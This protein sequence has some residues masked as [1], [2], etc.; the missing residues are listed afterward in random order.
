[1]RSKDQILLENLYSNQILKEGNV[2]DSVHRAISRRIASN[3]V[4]LLR[5]YG[6]EKVLDAVNQVASH[7][8]EG[9]SLEDIG[10]SDV[11]AWVNWVVKDLTRGEN[12]A[13]RLQNMSDTW[14][15]NASPEAKAGKEKL[16]SMMGEFGNRLGPEGAR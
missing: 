10:S 2:Y 6:I 7:V 12:T 4:D 5:D 8:A 1:M 16:S 14:D 11:S 15:K 3:H 9:E 13:E